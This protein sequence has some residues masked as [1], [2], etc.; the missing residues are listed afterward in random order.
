MLKK[1]IWAKRIV[2]LF[3][4]KIVGRMPDINLIPNIK[5]VKDL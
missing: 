2:E 4:Q 3:T 5:G 1:K